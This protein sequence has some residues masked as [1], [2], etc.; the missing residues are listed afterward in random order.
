[1]LKWLIILAVILLLAPVVKHIIQDID[2]KRQVEGK[3]P[4][5]E[6][7]DDPGPRTLSPADADELTPNTSLKA[8]LA[9]T[10]AKSLQNLMGPK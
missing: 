10:R 4:M 5:R 8:D 2:F 6:M 9:A 1:M 3:R 7:T